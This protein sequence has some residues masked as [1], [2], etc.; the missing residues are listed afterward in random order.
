MM[1]TVTSSLPFTAITFV[2]AAIC[3]YTG[4]A[5]PYPFD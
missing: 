5:P 1:N 3:A 2:L 4:A